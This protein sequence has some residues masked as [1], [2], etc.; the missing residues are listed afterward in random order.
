MCEAIF[1]CSPTQTYLPKISEENEKSLPQQ[2]TGIVD[3]GATHFYIAPNAPHEPLDTSAATIKVGTVNEQVATSAAN[4][5]PAYSI[6]G[7]RLT[8]NRIHHAR[9]YQHTCWCWV[10]L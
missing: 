1:S 8:Y 6:I 2:H 7:S 10:H 4:I 5:Y 9:F 3:S